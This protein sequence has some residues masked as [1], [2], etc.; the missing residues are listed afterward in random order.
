MIY[1]KNMIRIPGIIYGTH[2]AT[3]LIPILGEFL[4][5]RRLHASERNVLLGFYL[6]YLIIPAL[7]AIVLSVEAFPFPHKK[8]IRRE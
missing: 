2:V 6:P 8:K 4:M 7:F 1:K 5:D 3:T